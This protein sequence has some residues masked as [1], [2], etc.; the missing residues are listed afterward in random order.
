[1]RI[2]AWTRLDAGA[3][4]AQ[5][6]GQHAVT[7]RV[8]ITNLLDTR[9]WVESPTQFDHIYLFPMAE[10]AFNVSMQISF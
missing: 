9:A 2:P 7:W 4:L 6:W 10:R 8:G 3:S 1:V 5:N